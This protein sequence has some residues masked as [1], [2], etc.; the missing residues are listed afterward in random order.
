M[1]VQG[2]RRIIVPVAQCRMF[3]T[4]P[5][6]IVTPHRHGLTLWVGRCCPDAVEHVQPCKLLHEGSSS[7]ASCSLVVMYAHY[8]CVADCADA[9]A[10]AWE[11]TAGCAQ[12]ICLHEYLLKSQYIVKWGLHGIVHI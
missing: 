4:V 6:D 5:W 2:V 8:A 7:Y 10:D 3:T 12:A 11:D 1:G 9:M